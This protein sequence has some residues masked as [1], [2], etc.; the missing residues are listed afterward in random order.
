MAAMPFEILLVEDNPDDVLLISRALVAHPKKYKLTV[1]ADGAQA[2]EFLARQGVY[3]DA[4]RPGLI[5]LDLKLPKK[6]GNH[7]LAEIGINPALT[8]IPVIVLTSA[9][10]EDESFK[11]YAGRASCYV[12]KS[13][14]LAEFAEAIRRTVEFWLSRDHDVN[15]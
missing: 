9:A 6:D 8:D 10:T 7:V 13:I 12:K 2:C 14:D 4:P 5:L 3:A 11:T 1:I 15:S